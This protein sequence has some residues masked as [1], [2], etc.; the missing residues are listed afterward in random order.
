MIK[1]INKGLSPPLDLIVWS[2]FYDCTDKFNPMFLTANFKVSLTICPPVPSR[3]EKAG[4]EV[5]KRQ[6]DRWENSPTASGAP[7][8]MIGI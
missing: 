4:T 6:K 5:E 8:Y 3:F 1:I 7:G 2:S